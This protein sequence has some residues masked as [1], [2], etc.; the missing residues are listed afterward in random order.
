MLK[1]FSL[2]SVNQL[3]ATIKLIEVWKSINRE[4]YP[5]QL[6]PYNS[7]LAQSGLALRPKPERTFDDSTRLCMAESSFT[8]DAART[9]NAAPP[10]VVNAPSLEVAKKRIRVFA[11]S[12]P[13]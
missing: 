4:G 9:W 12:L 8:I 7:H 3:S 11:E 6:K 13:V 1:K 5:I 10:D 2:L